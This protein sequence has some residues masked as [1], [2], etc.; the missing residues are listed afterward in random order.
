M[1]EDGA[2]YYA[3]FFDDSQSHLG[4]GHIDLTFNANECGDSLFLYLN[5]A[6]IRSPGGGTYTPQ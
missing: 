5:S 3:C 2:P 1:P 6:V 4:K